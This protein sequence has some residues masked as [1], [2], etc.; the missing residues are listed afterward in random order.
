[1]NLA[2][3]KQAETAFFNKYPGGF[4]HPELQELG[5]K[6]NIDKM[7]DLAR[8]SFSKRKFNDEQHILECMVKVVSRS[9]MVSMFEKPKFR[10]FVNSL[11]DDQRTYLCKALKSQLHG[12][13]KRGFENMVNGLLPAKLAKWPLLTIIP[14]CYYPHEQVFVKPT[15]T[16]GVIQYFELE[17]LE[18]KPLPSWDFYQRYRDAFLKM[19]AKVDPFLA[20]NNAAFGGFLMMSI[21]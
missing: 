15:T 10:D 6:H 2:K 9:S 4:F 14:N 1:M 21:A 13:E 16:K 5:V 8:D 11:G 18:Y 19:K 12:S 3:L 7:I 17:E 20:P